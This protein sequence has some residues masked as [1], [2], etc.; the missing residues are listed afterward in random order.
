MPGGVAAS[1]HAGGCGRKFAR[2]A[3]EIRARHGVRVRPIDREGARRRGPRRARQMAPGRAPR[4]PPRKRPTARTTLCRGP[5]GPARH[6][7]W[8]C[9]KR[10]LSN[11]AAKCATYARNPARPHRGSNLGRRRQ[12]APPKPR[13]RVDR[14]RSSSLAHI[15]ANA[16]RAAREGAWGTPPRRARPAVRPP[17]S[18]HTAAASAT[19][20]RMAAAT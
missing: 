9:F 6:P 3:A 11:C 12:R 17:P 19:R 14:W 7:R 2:D 15:A 10:G 4:L 16:A 5:P 1:Y 20:P 18:P 8:H 13:G